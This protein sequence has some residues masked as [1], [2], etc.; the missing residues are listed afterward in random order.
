MTKRFT[1]LVVLAFV[2]ALALTYATSARAAA[3]FPITER[4]T[5][6]TIPPEWKSSGSTTLTAPVDG[7]GNGWLRLTDAVNTQFGSIV[8]D[9]AFDSSR[10]VLAEFSYATH[11]GTGADGLVF[12][13]Y[14]GATPYGSFA[15]GPAGGSIGYTNCNTPGYVAPG[16]TGAYIGVAFDEWG[17]FAN[18]TFCN[19]NGGLSGASLFPGRVV[20]RGGVANNYQYLGSQLVNH[21]LE[22]PRTDARR[23]KVAITP[24]MK[25]SVYITFPDG[26]I[27][28]V[29]S[30]FALPSTVPATLKMGFVAATGGSNNV[31]EIR[32]TNVV[33]PANLTTT[34]TD[35]LNGA[36]RGA[37]TWT[38][39]VTNSGP[40]PVTDAAISAT[41]PVAG[42]TNVTWTCVPDAGATCDQPSGTGLPST[43]A[44]LPSGKGVTYTLHADIATLGDYAQL[45]FTAD[46]QAGS[47]TGELDPTDNVATDTTYLTPLYTAATPPTFTLAANGTA[48]V[49]SNGTTW[50]G[51]GFTHSFQWQRCDVDG[52]GC[53]D[54]ATATS[55][56]YNT[57]AADAYKTLRLKVTGTNAAGDTDAYSDPFTQIPDTTITSGPATRVATTAATVAFSQTGGPV[58]TTFECS[59]DGAP[60]AACSS[61]K[62]LTGLAA[63]S[64]T[65]DVRAAYGGLVD[66]TPATRTWVVDLDATLTVTGPQP[67]ETATNQPTVTGTGEPGSTVTI[68]VD[69]VVVATGVVGPD[70]T[71]AIP[72]ADKLADGEHTIKV[73]VVDP[74]GNLKDAEVKLQVDATAPDAPKVPTGPATTSGSP[75]ATFTF[76]G[77]PG[78]TFKCRLDGGAWTVCT[79]P[80]TV[81]GLADGPHTLSVVAVDKLGNESPRRDYTWTV[82]TTKPAGPPVMSG[83]ATKTKDAKARF[84]VSVE[85][86]ATL[87]CS[88]DG[89][90]FTPCTSPIELTGLKSGKHTLLVRQIDVAGNVGDPVRYDWTVG[91]KGTDGSPTK[92]SARISAA[93][94]VTGNRNVGIGCKLDDGQA[95]RCSAKAYVVINGK[96]VLIGSGRTDRAGA[97]VPVKLNATGRRLLGRAIGGLQVRLLV[98]ASSGEVKG[99]TARANATLFPEKLAIVPTINP[100]SFDHAQMN[101]ASKKAIKALARSLKHAKAVRCVGNTDSVGSAAYNQALGLRRARTVCAALAKLGVKG[102]RASSAGES[103]PRASNATA[104]GRERN[105]R[106]E[107]RISY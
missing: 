103:T 22:A 15:T 64:H 75:A 43:T 86:G 51:G 31:H 84:D 30:N 41:A 7:E 107:L 97:V 73:S 76:D 90:T 106:V 53:A 52:T 25:L 71:F 102:A 88:L 104:A 78:S 66:A 35:G 21:G 87:E 61:P 91:A 68:K 62:N 67:G 34:V 39:T 100:F 49:T 36:A 2:G 60:Y 74:V 8:N 89:A 69:G 92:L 38:A 47:D 82:D 14:D 59:L 63:G 93:A 44:D 95:D 101:A 72:L 83:P 32:S 99:L 70:G 26:E 45:R 57:Q 10:G 12:F 33:Y 50:L 23:I 58:G 18:S 11:S 20:V 28:T 77:E 54:I 1:R 56:T 79:A 98:T 13:L 80:L 65:L 9:N 29:M 27:Q 46:H 17:N 24:D 16:L 105:R 40:N 6:S 19:Q 4:F 55:S 5:N 81:T 48:T 3:T 42:L 96:Q 85:P 94:T 37:N